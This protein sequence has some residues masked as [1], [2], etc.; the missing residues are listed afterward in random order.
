MADFP[1]KPDFG[2]KIKPKY[3]T[4]RKKYANN[5]DQVR[6][7]SSQKT[8]DFDLPFSNRSQTERNAVEDF[9]DAKTGAAT[10]F[11]IEI[12]GEEITVRFVE[13]SLEI[14]RKAP[15]IYDYS[16]QCEEVV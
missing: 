3:N 10:T 1:Y 15:G 14:V 6:L 11:T 12:D 13:E 5:V 8:R 4:L 7:M 9:Y 16:F 2:Y